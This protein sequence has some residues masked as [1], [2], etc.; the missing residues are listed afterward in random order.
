MYGRVRKVSADC[1]AT[2]V[3][4]CF[5]RT[6]KLPLRHERRQSPEGAKAVKRPELSLVR[7][8]TKSKVPKVNVWFKVAG[9]PAG[10]VIFDAENFDDRDVNDLQRAIRTATS[11]DFDNTNISKIYIKRADINEFLF[12]GTLLSVIVAADQG[13][14][15]DRPLLVDAPEPA[16]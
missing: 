16:G 4:F 7:R 14:T 12:P 10:K 15:P 9:N 5:I 2:A 8:K 3:P 1:S 11:P 6:M 13:K